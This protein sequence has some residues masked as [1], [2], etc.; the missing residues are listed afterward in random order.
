MEPAGAA[1]QPPKIPSKVFSHGRQATN[2][3]HKPP[4]RSPGEGVRAEDAPGTLRE[5]GTA[6]PKQPPVQWAA[7]P[8]P[9]Y[10]A[11]GKAGGSN[12]SLALC[13][14]THQRT[15]QLRQKYTAAAH[16]SPL[17]LLQ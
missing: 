11:P 14:G 9:A 12:S 13:N 10:L 15:H 3:S 17:R 4:I 2:I 1:S 8:E 6:S 7:V 5:S 16:V